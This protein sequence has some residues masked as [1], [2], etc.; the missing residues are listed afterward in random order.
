VTT[1]TSTTPTWARRMLLRRSLV[2][3]STPAGSEKMSI[4][5]S[6]KKYSKLNESGSLSVSR[7]TS[8]WNAMLANQ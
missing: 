3:A 8:H 5:I 6:M 2:S 1:L 4:G 7:A